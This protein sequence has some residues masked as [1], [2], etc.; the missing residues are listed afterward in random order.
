MEPNK[1]EIKSE[2]SET[3]K[4]WFVHHQFKTYGEAVEWWHTTDYDTVIEAV[5]AL[6]RSQFGT[7]LMWLTGMFGPQ[8]KVD[9]EMLKLKKKR[10]KRK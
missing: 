9:Y 7:E 8:E 3:V 4:E 10:K 5:G 2:V 1:A 6:G